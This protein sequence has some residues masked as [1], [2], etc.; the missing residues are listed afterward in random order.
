MV[1][2]N[3]FKCKRML[4]KIGTN[5]VG[6]VEGMGIEFIK[7][8]G[9]EPHYGSETH[10]HAVGTRHG[11]FTIRRWMFVDTKKKLLFDMYNDSTEFNLEFGVS[12]MQ[13]SP[14]FVT[15]MKIVLSDCLGYR[16]RPITGA[17]NDIIA[18]ELVGE[19]IDWIDTDFTD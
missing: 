1:V 11:T 4:V 3:P 9:S 14:D 6:V 17:T 2:S 8:G 7:E 19:F 10:R 18:E 5:V 16:W 13:P 15:G 12:D